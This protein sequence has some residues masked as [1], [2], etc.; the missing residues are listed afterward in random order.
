M[1]TRSLT[2]F[3]DKNGDI[4]ATVYKHW[5][6]H[7]DSMMPL[8]TRFFTRCSALSS[9]R[10][11]DPFYLAAKWVV[12][13]AENDRAGGSGRYTDDPLDFLGVGIMSP[14]VDAWEDYVYTVKCAND[15]Y[16][17]VTVKETNSV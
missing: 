14:G 17:L 1:A 10:F 9:P 13:L 2:T 15:A 3:A 5:D 11:D 12:F 16:P 8:F 6:G 4:M 7:P